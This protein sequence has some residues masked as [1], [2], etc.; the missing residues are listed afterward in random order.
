[1]NEDMY[2]YLNYELTAEPSSIFKES[3]MRK[4]K[5]L[6]LR[7]ALTDHI[8][9]N[10]PSKQTNLFYVVVLFSTKSVGLEEKLM[11]R[12]KEAMQSLLLKPNEQLRYIWLLYFVH[13]KRSCTFE[14]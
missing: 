7:K 11:N 5:I 12:Q 10:I 6:E 2:R 3:L 8:V 14:K 1:M 4:T 13:H 9:D